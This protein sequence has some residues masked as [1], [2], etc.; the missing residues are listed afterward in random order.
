MVIKQGYCAV[1]IA[2]LRAE[3]RDQAEIVSQLLFGELV[4]VLEL[5]LPW[6]K[7]TSLADGYTGYI[8][9]KHV[10][11]LSEKEVRRWSEGL[12]YLDKRETQLMTPWGKQWICR[13]SFL[14]ENTLEF[15]IGG[16]Q[17]VLDTPVKPTK[18][19]A[20]ELAEEYINTP[21]LWGGKTP[22]GIDCSGI[23]QVIYRFLGINL[24]RDASEQVDHG[25]EVSFDEIES[26][27]LAYFTNKLGKVT[28]VGI[29]D[30][31]GNIIHAS[32]CVRKDQLTE[33]GIIHASKNE[34]THHL[35]VIKRL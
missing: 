30:G 26:G 32:G 19:S 9:Y 33:D 28:H 21:Y 23:T 14:P 13:G 6:A 2:P 10:R 29:A 35:F 31:K 1:S 11:F 20:F 15:T 12:S 5:D 22:Y 27:D 18:L 8:D 4:D 25:F 3:N 17:F 24:P 7:V 16:D 34:L